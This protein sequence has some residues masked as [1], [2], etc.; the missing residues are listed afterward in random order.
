MSEKALLSLDLMPSLLS[1]VFGEN[2]L[3]RRSFLF[4]INLFSFCY[5]LCQLAGMGG[6]GV[7]KHPPG[8]SHA[9]IPSPFSSLDF[10]AGVVHH[11]LISFTSVSEQMRLSQSA[12]EYGTL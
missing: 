9:A 7:R 8:D 10:K 6:W 4:I 5:R 11:S 3:K 2:V 1:F 12:C